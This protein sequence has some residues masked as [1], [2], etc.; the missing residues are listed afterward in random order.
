MGYDIYPIYGWNKPEWIH[1]VHSGTRRLVELAGTRPVYAWIETS[2]GGQWTG[3][4][5]GQKEVTPEHIR[6]EVWMAICRGATAIG[7]FTHVWK[8]SYSQFGVPEE[9][10]K[11][12]VQINRQI[13]QLTPAILG[14]EPKRAVTVEAEDDAKI[15]VM[16]K[17][18]L[19]RLYVFAVNYDERL[20]KSSATVTVED[21]PAGKE[22]TVIDEARTIRSGDG[23][24]SDTFDPLAVHIYRID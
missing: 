22:I 2:R 13:T 19:G 7:Y 24:F 11:A 6:A 14:Q 17:E 16:A 3:P 15:D 5:E 10:R 20:V 1:L 18:H 9:N 21:L 12:L 8:P 4:L 23:S